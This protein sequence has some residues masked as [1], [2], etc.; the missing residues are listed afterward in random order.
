MDSGFSSFSTTVEK[1]D[2]VLKH[3][4]Q[5]YGW[6]KERRNQSYNALRAVLHALR[7]RLTVDET[8]HFASQLPMMIRGL[9]FDG[10]DPSVVPMKM[11]REEFLARVRVDFPFEIEGGIEH[12]VQTV[13]Q[14]L[15]RYVTQGEWDDIKSTMPKELVS[16]LP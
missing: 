11:S 3:I 14:A 7:D 6:P 9:Y 15:N 5:E 4:E 13:L 1:T 10:W 2:L 16:V 12:L 8:S